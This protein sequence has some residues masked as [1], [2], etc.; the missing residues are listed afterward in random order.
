MKW[1]WKISFI[2]LF[3]GLLVVFFSLQSLLSKAAAQELAFDRAQ[4]S[5]EDCGWSHWF[6]EEM[7]GSWPYRVERG[8]ERL[9]MWFQGQDENPQQ[10]LSLAR[11]RLETSQYVWEL[12]HH[13]V[14]LQTLYKAFLYL[15][16]AAQMEEEG[17]TMAQKTALADE[18]DQ[19]LTLW[20]TTDL[21]PAEQS[22]LSKLDAQLEALRQRLP[23]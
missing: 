4:D 14:A 17:V 9:A 16:Q 13:G 5:H 10:L 20:Q 6:D 23:E 22:R 19:L 11:E 1:P 2:L 8:Q 7:P 15:D 21:S 3:T 18:M 12:E